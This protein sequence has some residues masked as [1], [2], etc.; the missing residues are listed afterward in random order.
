[1]D[2][3]EATTLAKRIKS[4]HPDCSIKALLHFGKGDYAL[5]VKNNK[6]GEVF[7]VYDERSWVV[8]MVRSGKKFEDTQK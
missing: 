5:E 7:T 4:D 6:S 2:K 1:M 8:Y 3:D